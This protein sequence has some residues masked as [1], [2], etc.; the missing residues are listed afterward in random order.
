MTDLGGV[1]TTL[2]KPGLRDREDA[3]KV[4]HQFRKLADPA[5]APG[6]D[7]GSDEV[8]DGK[9]LPFQARGHT[10]IEVRG[11]SNDCDLGFLGH[12]FANQLTEGAIDAGQMAYHFEET[13][14]PEARCT[15]DGPD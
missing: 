13:D 7:L 4:V 15:N 14:D 11:I 8:N 6:P 3:E 5:L 12:S 10:E 9:A 1:Y 2:P